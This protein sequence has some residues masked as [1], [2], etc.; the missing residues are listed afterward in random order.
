MHGAAR[1]DAT[2]TGIVIYLPYRTPFNWPSLLEFLKP[3]AIRGVEMVEDEIYRRTIAI[4]G[5]AGAIEV[6]DQPSHGRLAMRVIFPRYDCLM[7]GV[8]RVRRL[9]DLGADM[10][11]I[12]RHLARD[13]RFATMV[14]ER[15][16]LR[17]PGAWDGFE[18]AVRAA[19]GQ[20]LTVVDTPAQTE[21][22]VR[23]FGRSVEVP[24]RGLS[25]LFPGPEILVEANLALE[26]SQKWYGSL[27]KDLQEIVDWDGAAASTALN[28]VALAM[29][30]E[31]RKAWVNGR[32]ELI[33]LPPDEQSAMMAML[34]SVGADIAKTKPALR[35][36]YQIVTDAARRVR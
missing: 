23:A 34:A 13:A 5:T 26:V 22:L 17:V 15:P 8:G 32:G 2:P 4:D 33:S 14:A 3:R 7:Q 19:L 25:H 29:Y 35:E 24:V 21:R 36:A 6:W 20:E 31:Q 10:L 18:M 12:E 11:H 30:A 16:G 1:T 27:P 9:F 28:P